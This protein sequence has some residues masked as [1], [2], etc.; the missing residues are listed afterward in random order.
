MK[1][2][3][4]LLLVAAAS[5]ELAPLLRA[6]EPVPGSYII[7]IKDSFDVSLLADSPILTALGGRVALRY[8]RV[9]HG[10]SAKLSESALS[11]VRNS[12]IIEY[13]EED[14]VAR[15][16][17][18]WGIDR[19]NQKSLPLDNNK[20]YTTK[21]M[22]GIDCDGHGTHCSGTVGSSSYGVATG[23]NIWGVRVLNCQG[24]GSWSAVIAGCDFAADSSEPLKVASLSIGGGVSVSVN[25]AIQRMIDADVAV[26]VAAGNEDSDACN[27]S[28]ASAPNCLTVGASDDTD[29]RASFSNFGSCVDI[30][31]P[32]VA[33][34]S[35]VLDNGVASWAGTS[36]AT[37]HVAGVMALARVEYPAKT[38][39]Q[40]MAHVKSTAS[41]GLISDPQGS[42]NNLL[43]CP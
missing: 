40:I 36:M 31:A 14:G 9:L 6:R 8:K 3:A 26:A 42:D 22:Y 19:V 20:D 30:F 11:F 39:E 35:T 33:I 4:L 37:P 12:G 16:A 28:P 41:T 15:K 10:F 34:T 7:R 24:S 21:K 43:Y 13:V 38:A 29:T 17:F 1:F 5:A 2:V 23:V 32:G 25:D 27:S 18:S